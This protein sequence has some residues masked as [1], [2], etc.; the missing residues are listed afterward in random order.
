MEALLKIL[1]AEETETEVH[2]IEDEL[3]DEYLTME[4]ET[5]LPQNE[6]KG[7]QRRGYHVEFPVLRTF[8]IVKL[9]QIRTRQLSEDAEIK[10]DPGTETDYYKIAAME[11][12]ERVLPL[13]IVKKFTDGFYEI[14]KI[15]EFEEIEGFN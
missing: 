4:T 13:K 5:L 6:L 15:E 9:L 12:K 3:Q 7:D 11:L 2:N 10:V 8:T 1:M 14:W